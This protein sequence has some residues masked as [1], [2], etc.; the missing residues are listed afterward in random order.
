MSSPLEHDPIVLPLVDG[1]TILDVAC[2][3]GKWGYLLRVNWWRTGKGSGETEPSVLIGVDVFLPFLKKVKYHKI[4]DDVVLCHVSYFPFKANSFEVVLASEILEHLDKKDGLLL[5]QE[6][7]RVSSKTIIVAT[8]HVLRKRGGLPTPE[9]FNPYERHVTKWG[10]N[11]LKSLGYRVMGT[12]FVF[13]ALSPFF[14]SLMSPISFL[15]P[16]LSTHLVA[17]KRLKKKSCSIG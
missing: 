11:E 3:R 6:A 13:L 4:Y 9:G 14:S 1:D 12:G 16:Q 7:E 15:I 5:L 2:G 8:P 17:K 10:I